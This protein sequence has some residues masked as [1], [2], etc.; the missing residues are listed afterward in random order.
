MLALFHLS[1]VL[2]VTAML[3]VLRRPPVHA[4]LAG[5]LLVVVLW[6]AGAADAW[7]LGSMLAAAED[8]AVLFASTAFVIV[9]GLAFVI[10]IE[11]LGVNLALSQWVQSLGLRRGDQLVFIVLGLAPL[12]EAM[13]GFGVSLI[14]TVPLLLSLFERQVALRIALAGMAIMPWGTLGLASVIGA[15]L[16]HV[17]APAL[18]A[19][20]AL[21]SAPVFLA[22]SAM[23]LYLAGVR[24]AREWRALGIFWLLFVAVLYA[25]SRWLGAEVAGV[26]AGLVTAGAV[27]AVGLWRL[28]RSAAERG[29]VQWPRQAWPYLL[30]IVYIVGLKTLWSITGWQDLWIVQGAQVTWKPLA[31]PGVAL[32]LVLIGLGF[33]TRNIPREASPNVSVLAALAAR[34]KRPLL[35]IFFFL[36]MS[37]MMVK[38][39]FLAGL[40]QLLAGLSPTAATSLVA[41]LGG[42]S[43]Y[44]TGSNVGGNAIFMPAIAMLPESSRLLLAAVQNSAA[45]H[46]AL[47]SLSIVMLILGLAKTQAREESALVRFGFG[48]VCLNTALVALSAMLLVG[49]LG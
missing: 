49:W 32:L 4:A 43:G 34:A 21:T 47:G 36:A 38:A 25:A 17:D 14:A 30:L 29:P 33:Y 5:T 46:A 13:T 23:A 8:T 31:S 18:A 20:S 10:F 1:P 7:R 9:P 27:L 37:Q 40:M 19:T 35:T 16:G 22:L 42:L 3:V 6:L 26:A 48:L 11:R 45:G 28:R 2:L 39:G 41:L 44:M 15:S 12:L 24:E